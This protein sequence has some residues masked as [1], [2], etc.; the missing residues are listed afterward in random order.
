MPFGL[1]PVHLIGWVLVA[2]FLLIFA[3]GFG[4]GWWIASRR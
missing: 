2:L 3:A 1:D 4:L